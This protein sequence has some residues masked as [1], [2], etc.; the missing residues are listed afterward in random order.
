MWCVVSVPRR[1]RLKWIASARRLSRR[2][3]IRRI[4]FFRR[5]SSDSVTLNA[6]CQRSQ[7]RLLNL[8]RSDLILGRSSWGRV[9]RPPP[10]HVASLLTVRTF[11]SRDR[12]PPSPQIAARYVVR[13]ISSF[14]RGCEKMTI[15][16]IWSFFHPR[17]FS[18]Q[19]AASA[20]HARSASR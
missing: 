16:S 2:R 13:I 9:D 7:V 6:P 1:L 12:L 11:P 15:C 14:A 17:A 19:A 10:T 18:L 8:R 4:T 3:S 5:C 20:C